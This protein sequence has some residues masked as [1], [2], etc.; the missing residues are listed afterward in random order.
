MILYRRYCPKAKENDKKKKESL[1]SSGKKQLR[2]EE[3]EKSETEK[4]SFKEITLKNAT[5]STLAI[6]T[7]GVGAT[8]GTLIRPGLG[9]VVGATIGD[10]I[11]YVI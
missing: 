10:T 11:A 1:P 9:T 5:R 4:K 6:L 3:D 7:G 8:I 2:F